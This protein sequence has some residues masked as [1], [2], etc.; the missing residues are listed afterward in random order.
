MILL[1]SVN[2]YMTNGQEE[3]STQ[4]QFFQHSRRGRKQ[5]SAFQCDKYFSSTKCGHHTT[6]SSRLEKWRN[7]PGIIHLREYGESS[8]IPFSE[9]TQAALASSYFQHTRFLYLIYTKRHSF[10]PLSASPNDI[11]TVHRCQDIC[12]PS[13]AD[14]D[15]NW[16]EVL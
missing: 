6:Q 8:E 7:R 9:K 10:L 2:A 4:K 3:S 15:Y 1:V 5:P 14:P 11:Q 13:Y 12:E 16:P